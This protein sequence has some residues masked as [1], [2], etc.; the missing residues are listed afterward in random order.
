ME[1]DIQSEKDRVR[2]HKHVETSCS[3]RYF[4]IVSFCFS[5]EISRST[6]IKCSSTAQM[7]APYIH[8]IIFSYSNENQQPSSTVSLNIVRRTSVY[9]FAGKLSSFTCTNRKKTKQNT[10]TKINNNNKL[11]LSSTMDFLGC[12]RRRRLPEQNVSTETKFPIFSKY[13]FE[14]GVCVCAR[15]MFK[16]VKYET[17]VINCFL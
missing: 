13:D 15:R 10:H 12:C 1:R 8:I 3:T 11:L 4:F 7:R 5:L 14:L 16:C 9:F 2:E 6:W 17:V